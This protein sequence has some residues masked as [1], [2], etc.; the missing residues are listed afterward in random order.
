M[1]KIAYFSYKGG[2]GRSSLAYNTI[3]ILAEELNATPEQ[4]IILLDL[5]VDSA[6]LTFLLNVQDNGYYVQDIVNGRIPGIIRSPE[7]TPISEHPF[8]SKLVP[9][10]KKFGLSINKNNSILF[11]P[12]KTGLNMEF[13]YDRPE[14]YLRGVEKLCKKYNCKAILFDT[15]AGDQLT[16]NWSLE[17]AKD[18][19]TTM[20]ITYQFRRGT[21]DFLKRK[22]KE[23][24]EKNFILVPNC[25]PVETIEIDGVKYNYDA[26]RQDIIIKVKE[27]MTQNNVNTKMLEDG[28]FG[29][30][31]VKRFKL[32]EGILYK[33]ETFTEDE[34]KAYNMYNKVVELLLKE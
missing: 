5:D 11:L 17:V 9:V 21:I 26:V 1:K 33:L 34:Q 31:E 8:F 6:G 22:D 28:N 18:I 30:P 7:D 20:K 4:P 29:I 15:P 24:K 27:V 10:G 2:A 32:E 25:V 14:N 13:S 19:I 12:V 3:P 23:Y 16:A